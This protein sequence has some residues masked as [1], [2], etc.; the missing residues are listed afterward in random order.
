L[1]AQAQGL[2]TRAVRRRRGRSFETLHRDAFMDTIS[3][4]AGRE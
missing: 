2:V 1:A 4:L 3:L